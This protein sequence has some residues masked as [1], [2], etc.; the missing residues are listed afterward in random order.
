MRRGPLRSGPRIRMRRLISILILFPLAAFADGTLVIAGGAVS[1][2]NASVYRAFVDAIPGKGKVAII[3]AASGSP[4]ESARRASDA[5]SRY[6]LRKKD[7][8]H[9][10][11]AVVDDDSTDIVDESRWMDNGNSEAELGRLEGV[12][13]VWI[14][15]GDQSR[16]TRVLL[17]DGRDTAIL[18]ALRQ[19]LDDGG[20]IGGTSAGAA[21]MSHPM[22]L[23]GDTLATLLD[24]ESLGERLDIG[25][26]IGFFDAGLV[27]QH[28]DARARL[29]RLAV[30]L[31]SL[32]ESQ[33]LG[34]GIDENSAMLVSNN[35]VRVV[36]EGQLT[37]VDARDATWALDTF[38][39]RIDGLRV[40]VLSPGDTL[41]LPSLRLRPAGY[42]KKTVGNEYFS[43]REANAA[44]IAAPVG[45]LSEQLGQRL[46][47]NKA[48]SR[49]SAPTLV[50]QDEGF[51]VLRYVFV[52]SSD[53]EG[54]WGYEPDGPSR[55]SLHRVGLS[56]HID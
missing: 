36:G 37:V 40:S 46:L 28:F 17:A 22:I 8:V 43:R 4:V 52:Q 15:G 19:I 3:S 1:P 54:W 25:Q 33:R 26:G 20:V 35:D 50:E 55:Y 49:W 45:R 9:L 38:G 31:Q 18:G 51:A 53:S 56:I 47:D 5:L 7:I 14:T 44:G 11:L 34:F 39:Y 23:F 16:L 30:A 27:D 10:R 24:D 32:P 29:G 48:A 2:D 42:L 21:I 13:G 41:K 12:R 6:G